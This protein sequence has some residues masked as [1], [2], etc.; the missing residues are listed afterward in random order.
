VE[1]AARFTYYWLEC[2]VEADDGQGRIVPY[3]RGSPCYKP[4]PYPL[5]I[6]GMDAIS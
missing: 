1:E 2:C 6:P 3:M 5:P 4:L